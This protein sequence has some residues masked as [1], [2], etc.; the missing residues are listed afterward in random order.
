MR[1]PD[2]LPLLTNEQI[3]GLKDGPLQLSADGQ[4]WEKPGMPINPSPNEP[5]SVACDGG[6][7]G[8]GY[9][10]HLICTK[11]L[12]SGRIVI[13]PSKSFTISQQAVRQ[14]FWILVGGAAA[15]FIILALLHWFHLL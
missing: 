2:R 7:N 9:V 15:G 4:R 8:R 1:V 6:C 13:Y 11:C 5:Y 12:G 10:G 3:V 14:M